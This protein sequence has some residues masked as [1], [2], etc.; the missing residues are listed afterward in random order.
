MRTLIPLLIL[1]LLPLSCHAID[2]YT[3][4]NLV[5]LG[6]EI[7]DVETTQQLFARDPGSREEQSAWLYGNRPTRLVM[8]PM[9]LSMHHDLNTTMTGTGLRRK[10]KVWIPIFIGLVALHTVDAIHNSQF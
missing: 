2:A 8:Y 1:S 4:V 7:A 9:M 3:I 5:L 10:K 6:S